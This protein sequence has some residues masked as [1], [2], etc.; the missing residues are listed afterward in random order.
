M[1][2]APNSN[3]L[4]DINE[5]AQ[6]LSAALEAAGI[7]TWTLYP[8]ASAVT[9]DDRC[10]EL[11]GFAREEQVPYEE[12]LRYIHPDDRQKVYDTVA[13][14]LDPAIRA[15]YEVQFRTI[16]AEDKQ[17]RWL[18]CKGRAYF[19]EQGVVN[20]FSGTAQDITEIIITRERIAASEH[21]ARLSL[22]ASNA[23]SFSVLLNSNGI[24]YS[25]ACARILTGDE[26]A[27]LVRA[28]LVRHI[29][30]D[31][32]KIRQA[33]YEL[34]DS[35]GKLNY[36]A[37]TIWKDGSIHWIHVSGSYLKDTTGRYYLFA[38]TLLDITD[39]IEQRKQAE[40]LNT[41]IAASHDWMGI[42]DLTGRCEFINTTGCTLQGIRDLAVTDLSLADICTAESIRKLSEKAMPEA[43]A[44]GSWEGRMLFR[45]FGNNKISIPVYLR[46]TLQKDDK[47]LPNALLVV[48]RDLRREE[49]ANLALRGAIELAELATW[50]LDL[51]T[52]EIIYSNRLQSWFAFREGETIYNTGHNPIHPNERHR[53][54]DAIA[55]AVKDGIFN[56]E[57]TTVEYR[58]GNERIIHA[59]GKLVFNEAGEPLMLSGT[60]QDVTA[61]RKIQF[62]LEREVQERTEELVILNEE[63][64]AT[65]EELYE[66]NHQL[67]HSNEE[68]AQYA[69]VASHDL[70]EPLRKIRMFSGMLDKADLPVHNQLLVSKI[71]QSA[72]R[73]TQLIR[74]LLE[75]SRLLKTDSLMR[76]VNLTKIM[77][78]VVSDF[79][80]SV[81]EKMADIEVGKLPVIEGVSLQ[82]NQLFYNLIGNALK[83]TR[84]GLAPR[85]KI[86][87]INIT[88]EEA[89]LHIQKMTPFSNY[90]RITLTDNGIGFETKYAEQIFEVF[91]RLHGKELYP[92][93]GIGLAL[94]RRIAANHQGHLYAESEPGVGTSFHLLLPDRQSIYQPTLPEHFSWIRDEIKN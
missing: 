49:A 30:P 47:G 15:A 35:T 62:A 1:K 27:R 34:A 4:P 39:E 14:S 85:I 55:A 77:K 5:E 2:H 28:D 41:L 93:S 92:G 75:F 51:Q 18:Y 45:H 42:T 83:F 25:P 23:G 71:N 19:D 48:A 12:V 65:N 69:Y 72:E 76:P 58:T 53:L 8:Q 94:C 36:K 3:A 88:R 22:D 9:W 68:L 37:R 6:R 73:M 82:I 26:G 56:V 78:A 44:Q 61:Q 7:G 40:R 60:A 70:Q 57:C 29:H 59:Q 11:Y 79:E 50:T 16:G 81:Q 13:R 64:Q 46:I 32:Q 54:N 52:R 20:R 10:R 84:P 80:L 17:L 87:A 21:W 33:A 38:G 91:K 86:D 63:L 43:L 74:D 67:T 90:Y 24:E 89:G 66:S 31:D